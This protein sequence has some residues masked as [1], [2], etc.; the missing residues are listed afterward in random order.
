MKNWT[1]AQQTL[2]NTYSDLRARLGGVRTVEEVEAVN[3]DVAEVKKLLAQNAGITA[4]LLE[5]LECLVDPECSPVSAPRR[6]TDVWQWV[7]A[8][9]TP[10]IT[11][12]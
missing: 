9:R 5:K 4:E 3:A 11:T 12:Y 2:A 10:S 8:W 6:L 1:S 7:P